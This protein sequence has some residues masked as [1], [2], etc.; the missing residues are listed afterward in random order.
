MSNA[1]FLF[2]PCNE[3]TLLEQSFK[4]AL[5][6]LFLGNNIGD[7]LL[8]TT[9]PIGTMTSLQ[10]F[11]D[12]SEAC[13]VLHQQKLPLSSPLQL[14]T[15]YWRVFQSKSERMQSSTKL[16]TSELPETP[17]DLPAITLN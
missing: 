2:A 15:L 16:E 17:A 7:Y 10:G 1:T 13:H 5:P 4:A 6:A 3:F 11:L 12:E 8:H 9:Q 14:G